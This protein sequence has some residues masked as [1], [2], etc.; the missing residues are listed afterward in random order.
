M[1]LGN[2]LD[3]AGVIRIGVLD[4]D[5]FALDAMCAMISAMSRDFR[6]MWGTGSPAVA[7]EHCH[8]AHTRP[9]VLVLDMA[10]GGITGADVC[11]RIRRRTSKVG[12]ICVTS[13]STDVYRDEAI[14]AGAQG[15]LAKERLKTDI[16]EAVRRAALGMPTAAQVEAGFR[17]AA[18]AHAA[19]SGTVPA[20]MSED[21]KDSLSA[22]EKDILRLYAQRLTTDEIAARL[23]ITKGSVFTYVHRAA[24]KLGV[25]SRRE[26]LEACARYDLL[27]SDSLDEPVRTTI[28]RSSLL[29]ACC[30]LRPSSRNTWPGPRRM[31]PQRRVYSILSWFW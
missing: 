11:R 15:L 24:D 2:E 28:I 5:P 18:S 6:V 30:W 20:K 25:T 13:Y 23:G 1:G 31:F 19:L 27:Q 22:R 14:A 3:A 29:P 16:D 7:I 26:V 12:V 17:D 9:D 8:N 10:L 21:M 4:N